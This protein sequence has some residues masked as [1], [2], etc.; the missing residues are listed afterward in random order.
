MALSDVALRVMRWG[1]AVRVRFNE[2]EA[3]GVLVVQVR[4]LGAVS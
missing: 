2:G 3:F 1:T 4:H